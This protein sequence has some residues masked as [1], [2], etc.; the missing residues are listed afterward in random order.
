MQPTLADWLNRKAKGP[1]PKK[2]L[3]KVAKRNASRFRCYAKEAKAYKLAH[4]FCGICHDGK[5]TDVHHTKG[6]GPFLL[7]QSTW[8]PVC[9]PCHIWVHAMPK[10]ARE[11]GLLA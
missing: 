5:T 3:P 7:D 6:R 11:L 8:L 9:R 4:P 2:R 10:E 1:A